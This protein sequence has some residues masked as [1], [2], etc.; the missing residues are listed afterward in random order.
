MDAPRP[1]GITKIER[2]ASTSPDAFTLLGQIIHDLRGPMATLSMELYSAQR[3]QCTLDEP[4]R[5]RLAE[6]LENVGQLNA[7]L[8]A[9]VTSLQ[10][11]RT[12][13]R[14]ASETDLCAADGGGLDDDPC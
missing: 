5:S 3:V 6:I 4:G 2:L 14:A 11:T 1:R 12:A 7:S 13:L 8:A 10:R 9:Y